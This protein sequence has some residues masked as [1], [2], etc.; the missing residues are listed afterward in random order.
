MALINFDLWTCKDSFLKNISTA[1][2]IHNR[3]DNFNFF[4]FHFYNGFVNGSCSYSNKNSSINI[5]LFS[6]YKV[7]NIINNNFNVDVYITYLSRV[8]THEFTHYLISEML[9][10]GKHFSEEEIVDNFSDTLITN[11]EFNTNFYK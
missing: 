2:P 8:I 3:S 1:I 4:K 6:I 10:Y 9:G 7:Y 11:R 5:F